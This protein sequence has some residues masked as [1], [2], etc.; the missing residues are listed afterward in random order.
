MYSTLSIYNTNQFKKYTTLVINTKFVSYI[1]LLFS[2]TRNW[3][4]ALVFSMTG[5]H[6]YHQQ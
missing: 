5:D 3:C 4:V 1:F 6:D 2:I